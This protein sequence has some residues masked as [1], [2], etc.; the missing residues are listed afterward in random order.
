MNP[1]GMSRTAILAL[2]DIDSWRR[3]DPAQPP[4]QQ[5]E[6][7]AQPTARI[8]AAPP[9]TPAPAAAA[10]PPFEMHCQA[11]PPCLFLLGQPPSP[12]G[13]ELLHNIAGTL[14][15]ELAAAAVLRWPPPIGDDGPPA[16]RAALTAFLQD[17]WR[18]CRHLL[19]F[20][21]NAATLLRPETDSAPLLRSR[22][23]HVRDSPSHS[24][25]DVAP[26]QTPTPIILPAL[27]Q[28]LKT[29]AAKAQCWQKLRPLA[30]AAE[31]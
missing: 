2:M 10:H 25:K 16:A 28:M 20:G 11:A 4:E 21:E 29:P 13:A 12:D 1:M 6:A 22:G 24:E 18:D 19:I 15:L 7:V 8:P 26:V 17:Q 31:H 14:G 5:R 23:V 27:E 9:D 3:R 30:S